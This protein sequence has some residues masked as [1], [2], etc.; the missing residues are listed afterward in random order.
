M[1]EC[2]SC[3]A[4]QI[5]NSLFCDECGTELVGGVKRVFG[6][7]GGGV[8]IKFTLDGEET[9][10]SLR[11]RLVDEMLIGR[12]NADNGESP[13]IDLDEWGGVEAGVSRRHA[14]LR[15]CGDGINLKD[16]GS[17]NG[18]RIN[19]KMLTPYVEQPLSEGDTLTL[20]GLRVTVDILSVDRSDVN[21]EG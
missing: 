1:I 3:G 6:S 13:D 5:E 4:R 10:R 15:L 17:I 11:V 8:D 20:G 21:S 16:L 18:T 9:G 19:D 12:L 14:V 2:P 7:Q